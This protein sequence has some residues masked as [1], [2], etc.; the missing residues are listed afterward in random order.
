M[1]FIRDFL[2]NH[3]IEQRCDRG[4]WQ[5]QPGEVIDF[6]PHSQFPHTQSGSEKLLRP[7]N[8]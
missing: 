3:G 8:P 6:V 5:L 1:Q 2:P 4:Q 7:I